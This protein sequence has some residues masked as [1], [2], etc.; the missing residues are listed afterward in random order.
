MFEFDHTQRRAKKM[1]WMFR[2]AAQV[3]R[4]VCS[5]LTIDA[6]FNLRRLAIR[7]CPNLPA[8]IKAP[9]I[10]R[11][12]RAHAKVPVPVDGGPMTRSRTRRHMTQQ[13]A[14]GPLTRSRARRLQ[15]N[16]VCPPN[17]CAARSANIGS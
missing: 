17:A 15:Q 5:R 14:Q 10:R 13:Q 12:R 11:K 7:R 16:S 4:T 1:N 9:P 3:I 6:Y 8:E 2:G